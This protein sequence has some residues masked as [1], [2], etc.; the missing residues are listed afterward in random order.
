MLSGCRQCMQDLITVQ[1][2]CQN[3]SCLKAF[4]RV[5]HKTLRRPVSIIRSSTFSLLRK[6]LPTLI[7]YRAYLPNIPF[8]NAR[9]DE[10]LFHK[11]GNREIVK[12]G[13]GSLGRFLHYIFAMSQILRA[14]LPVASLQ[15]R[16]TPILQ[17]PLE[18]I[19]AMLSITWHFTLRQN[20]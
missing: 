10:K 8:V 9:L 14:V 5:V 4:L 2:D 13:T 3:S 1:E 17:S 16:S 7:D 11:L 19:A 15:I 18:L 20:E 12:R 6:P